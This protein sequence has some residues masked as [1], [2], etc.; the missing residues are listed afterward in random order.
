MQSHVTLGGMAHLPTLQVRTAFSFFFFE[1]SAATV[2]SA[3]FDAATVVSPG[4]VVSPVAAVSAVLFF[5]VA[6]NS[7][8]V[9]MGTAAVGVVVRARAQSSPSHPVSQLQ[10]PR[11][12]IPLTRGKTQRP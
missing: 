6:T 3:G 8:V 11:R 1:T 10:R 4:V 9:S 5:V 12:P 7:V 2:V